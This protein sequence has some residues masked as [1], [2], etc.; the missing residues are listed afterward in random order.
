[1]GIAL[2]CVPQ[3][4]CGNLRGFKGHMVLSCKSPQATHNFYRNTLLLF[5]DETVL[6]WLRSRV[7]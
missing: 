6:A 5:L 7:D 1:V 3:T 4:E 2:Q